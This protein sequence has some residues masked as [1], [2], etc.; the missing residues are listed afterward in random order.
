[1]SQQTDRHKGTREYKNGAAKHKANLETK[2][3]H[4]EVL[5]RTRRISVAINSQTAPSKNEDESVYSKPAAE[6]NILNQVS[7]VSTLEN[8]NRIESQSSSLNDQN[9]SSYFALSSE[10]NVLNRVSSDI[11][12]ISDKKVNMKI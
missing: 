1:M 9:V 6:G 7:P 12:Q 11:N 2:K 10:D 3:K 5:A 8:V 4:D